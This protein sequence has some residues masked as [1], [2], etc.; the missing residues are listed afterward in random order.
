M[1]IHKCIENNL[2]INSV[3]VEIGYKDLAWSDID[4]FLFKN[5]NI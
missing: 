5:K 2:E 4:N 1:N 3:I